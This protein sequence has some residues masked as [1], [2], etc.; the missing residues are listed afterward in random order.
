MAHIACLGLGAMGSRMAARLMA[1]GHQVTVWNRTSKPAEF[2]ARQGALLAATPRAAVADAQYV[3]TM[4]RD[5]KASRAVWLD[6]ETGALHAMPAQALAIDCSTL[7]LGWVKELA[8]TAK[9]MGRTFL[10]APVAGS[11][12]QAEGGQLIFLVGGDEG[13]L[14]KAKPILEMMGQAIHHVGPNGHGAAVKLALNALFAQ[15]VAGI[16]ELFGLLKAQGVDVARA[17]EIIGATPVAS[18]AVKGAA[19]QML[20]GNFAP[21]FPI[22]LVTK[23]LDYVAIAADEANARAPL[24]AATCIAMK[25]AMARGYGSDNLTSIVRLYQ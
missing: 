22:E 23:D 24:S 1:A 16:A 18:P 3:I 6:R 17:F 9:N 4:V 7:T 15:Q 19:A 11:R 2:L 14:A 21:L 25:E 8:E 10:D 13:A 20:A 5:D 12:P